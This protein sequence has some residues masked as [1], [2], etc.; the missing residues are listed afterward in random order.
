MCTIVSV[1]TYRREML[2]I[3][4]KRSVI[5]PAVYFTHASELGD[6]AA[7]TIVAM[8]VADEVIDWP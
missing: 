8:D 1:L 3:S 7:A 2:R 5:K 6:G 4:S